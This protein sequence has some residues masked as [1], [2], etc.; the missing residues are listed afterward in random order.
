MTGFG[1]ISG[2][3]G[4]VL[5]AYVTLTRADYYRVSVILQADTIQEIPCGN[6][7]IEVEAK[8]TPEEPFGW[9]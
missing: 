5:V 8:S 4:V 6:C 7:F 9:I 2:D 3:G 1:R